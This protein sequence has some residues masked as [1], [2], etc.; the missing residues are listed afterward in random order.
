M[1]PGHACRAF[2]LWDDHKYIHTG[3]NKAKQAAW[4]AV[5]GVVYSTMIPTKN[6]Q[7]TS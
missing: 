7:Q 3:R 1:L 5:D 2:V 6:P 4:R